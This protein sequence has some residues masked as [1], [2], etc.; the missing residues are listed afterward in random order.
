VPLGATTGAISVTTPGGTATSSANFTI[1]ASNIPVI[2][3]VD[4]NVFTGADVFITGQNLDNPTGITCGGI[5]LP[6]ANIIGFGPTFIRVTV[7][8]SWPIGTNTLVVTTA[9]GISNSVQLTITHYVNNYRPG[10]GAYSGFIVAM[11]GTRLSTVNSVTIGGVA[12]TFIV[13]NDTRINVTVPNFGVLGDKA[14]TITTPLGGAVQGPYPLRVIAATSPII[15][16]I[17]PLSGPIGSVVVIDGFNLNTVNSVRIGDVTLPNGTFTVVNANRINAIVP[18]GAQSDFF[19]NVVNPTTGNLSDDRFTVTISNPSITSFTPAS[20]PLGSSVTITGTNF[21]SA[22]A[23][24]FNN[25][26]AASFTVNSATQITATV[27]AGTATGLIRVTTP[28]STA[29][30][31]SNFTITASVPTITTVDLLSAPVNATITITGTNLSGA[32]VAISSQQLNILSNNGTTITVQAPSFALSGPMVVTTPAGAV[33]AGFFTHQTATRVL[34]HRAASVLTLAGPSGA[35]SYQWQVNQGSG[36]NNLSNGGVYA[37][38]NSR[39]L[40]VNNIPTSATGFQYRVVTNG[41]ILQPAFTLRFVTFARTNGAWNDINTWAGGLIPDLNTDVIVDD[42]SVNVNVN[43]AIR[44]LNITPSG[45]LTVL[46]NINL[47]IR[48]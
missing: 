30:S 14:V 42:V 35:S 37:G 2:T 11:N 34:Y 10:S 48:K 29:T 28:G 4:N 31:I 40:T 1:A 43:A 15:T 47:T 16:A 20:G 17:S 9:N 27:A 26:A 21:T 22:S 6:V 13:V 19:I 12:A 32:Q 23:V 33:Q 18:S 24:S 3:I 5:T 39:T 41:T 45:Q 44:T 36:F 38:V 46:N 8:A 25:V 7:P